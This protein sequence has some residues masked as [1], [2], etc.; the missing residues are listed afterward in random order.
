MGFRFGET[1][2]TVEDWFR[3]LVTASIINGLLS[4]FIYDILKSFFKKIV[5][6]RTEVKR[7]WR[8]SRTRLLFDK[9]G[10]PAIHGYKEAFFLVPSNMSPFLDCDLT[11]ERMLADG[12]THE[13]AHQLCLERYRYWV[14]TSHDSSV[15]KWLLWDGANKFFRILEYGKY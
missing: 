10:R 3:H 15:I 14:E 2:N 13:E 12:R 7:D 1:V 11:V 4:H 8:W 9:T 5:S 6:R